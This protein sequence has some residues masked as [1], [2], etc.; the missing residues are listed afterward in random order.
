[1][2]TYKT[3]WTSAFERLVKLAY[4]CTSYD[5]K[6]SVLFFETQQKRSGH[7]LKDLDSHSVQQ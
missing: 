4:I 2:G 1:M 6:S 5:Q 3:P 7:Q